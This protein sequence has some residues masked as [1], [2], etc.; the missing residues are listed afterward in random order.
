[1]LDVGRKFTNVLLSNSSLDSSAA[2]IKPIIIN[3]TKMQVG[4]TTAVIN[5]YTRSPGTIY[6]FYV[7][8]AYPLIN[9]TA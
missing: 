8:A 9:S 1:L 4:S 6:Y 2:L 7:D 3:M 5:V